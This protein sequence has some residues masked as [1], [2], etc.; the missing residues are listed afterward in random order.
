MSENEGVA[1]RPVRGERTKPWILT[2]EAVFTH[3]PFPSD[4]ES[5]RARTPSQV[6]RR[7]PICWLVCAQ[8]QVAVANPTVTVVTKVRLM[9][10]L[11]R[12]GRRQLSG[13]GGLA[14]TG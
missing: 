8:D 4:A 5:L 10:T 3:L 2:S 13:W 7:L 12:H 11:V 14:S 1:M 9:V 6:K